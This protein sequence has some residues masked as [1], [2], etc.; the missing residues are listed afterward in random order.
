MGLIE[1]N[2]CLSPMTLKQKYVIYFNN[3]GI[4]CVSY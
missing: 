4:L 2:L 3:K 1:N